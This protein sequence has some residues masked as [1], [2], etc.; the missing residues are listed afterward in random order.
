MLG[1]V[2]MT[3]VIIVLFSIC[4]LILITLMLLKVINNSAKVCICDFS[5]S[6]QMP[7]VTKTLKKIIDNYSQKDLSIVIIQDD[8]KFS[9][10]T[11]YWPKGCAFVHLSDAN[12]FLQR[13]STQPDNYSFAELQFFIERKVLIL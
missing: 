9:N 1:G 4:I 13:Y 5:I 12:Y 3:T 7:E 6:N 8:I 11:F 10:S 2:Q